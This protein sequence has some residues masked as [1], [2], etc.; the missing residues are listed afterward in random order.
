MEK[1]ELGL[2]KAPSRNNKSEVSMR[3][4]N[5]PPASTSHS[6]TKKKNNFL[7]PPPPGSALMPKQQQPP[8][9]LITSPTA[10]DVSS[11]APVLLPSPSRSDSE[12][13]SHSNHMRG[14]SS[15]SSTSLQGSNSPSKSPLKVK[16]SSSKHG[17][18][19]NHNRVVIDMSSGEPVVHEGKTTKDVV[20][21]TKYR[22]KKVQTTT[23]YQDPVTGRIY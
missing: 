12:G 19:P 10:Q 22:R 13:I 8:P 2:E 9:L 6:Q 16:L 21:E 14:A 17:S 5:A 18:S 15:S 1:Q 23:H 20:D 4:E 7:V 11:T 3:L